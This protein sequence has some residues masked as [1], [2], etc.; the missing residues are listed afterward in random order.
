[1]L[2]LDCHARSSAEAVITFADL[3]RE[4]RLLCSWQLA[5]DVVIGNENAFAEVFTMYHEFDLVGNTADTLMLI[6]TPPDEYFESLSSVDAN[7][8]S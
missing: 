2:A 3:V 7:R 1:M 6:C 5:K 4:L 8:V